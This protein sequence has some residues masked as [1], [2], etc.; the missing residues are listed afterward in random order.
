M[1]KILH[2]NAFLILTISKHLC[3]KLIIKHNNIYRTVL[4]SPNRIS[5]NKIKK[6]KNNI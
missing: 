2:E 5:S 4:K 1:Q 6:V 3:F